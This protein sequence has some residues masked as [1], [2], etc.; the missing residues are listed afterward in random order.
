M[1][2]RY[3][4]SLGPFKE[5]RKEL[6]EIRGIRKVKELEL[7]IRKASEIDLERFN[8]SATKI[9]RSIFVKKIK[10]KRKGKE[11][12]EQLSK[13]PYVVRNGFIK[14]LLLKAASNSLQKEAKHTLKF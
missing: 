3:L 1:L 10:E 2:Q 9:Q 11:I 13:L 5:A 8:Q 7:R 14:M 12:R 6:K 4:K